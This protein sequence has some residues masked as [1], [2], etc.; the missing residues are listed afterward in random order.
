M[1]SKILLP[2]SNAAA[3]EIAQP[4][5]LFTLLSSS[6]ICA[7]FFTIDATK[8]EEK[9]Q[10]LPAVSVIESSANNSYSSSE[11]AYHKF[12]SPLIDT[13]R[14]VSTVTR[15]FMD[16][17]GATTV[18]D[19]LRNV[20]GITLAA[21]EGG[22]QGDNLMIRGFS[23][24]NDFFVDGMRDFGNY[25]RDPFNLESIE[26]LQGPSSVLF[27]RGSTGGVVQQ[28]SK[29][30]F[31]GSKKDASFTLGT[32][33]TVRATADV[34]T[35]IEG[36]DGAAF[37]LNA[38]G[39]TNK[40]AGRDAAQYRRA[41]FAPNVAFG[42]GT[43]TRLNIN[44]LHQNED[45]IPDYGVPFFAG[46]P[47][48]VKRDNFY[49]FQSNDHL[50]A[51]VDIS[52][53]KFEHDFSKDLTLRN[54]T[55]YARYTRDVSVTE[56]QITTDPAVTTRVMKIRKSL[57]TYLGNQTDLTSKFET[58]GAAHTVVTGLAVESETSSPTVFAYDNTTTNTQNPAQ[59][60]FNNAAVT[61]TSI[62]KTKI[63]TLGVY[64][65]D[66]IKL[67]KSWEISLGGRF[68]NM[69]SE[70]DQLTLATNTR[71]N[72]SHTDNLFSYSGGVVYK[73]AKN[74]SVY[75]N[76][77]TSFNPSAESLALTAPTANLAPE[78]NTMYEVGTKWDLFKK[79]LSTTM[80]IF[81]IDKD[82]AREALNAT[83]TVLSGS[84]RVDGF[85]FQ[86]SGKLTDNWNLMLGYTFMN[87]RVTKSLISDTYKNRALAN[88][89]EH[90]ASLFTTYKFK[91]EFEVG[92][93]TNFVS[94]R[95]VTPTAAPDVVSGAVR[96]VPSYLTFNLMAKYPLG[97]NITMQLNANNITNKYYH[98]QI[99][100]TQ[101]VVPGEGRVVLLTTNIKF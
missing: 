12:S 84:Q 40:V 27:G 68:D 16:D 51:N 96:N 3:S 62:T 17:R 92:G 22:N 53:I 34:N 88:T 77:G 31:L 99:R 21:G 38:V 36:I 28:N 26:V 6:V 66:T 70:L 89:P 79:R 93:G 56:P 86:A 57:E 97:K 73:P 72:L 7:S 25:F 11:S 63:D 82:N 67:G 58:F 91:S 74:G 55:R 33:E 42:L 87:S 69:Q 24:R 14:T 37:R 85:L 76:H 75:F 20:P 83:T 71:V 10:E 78:K 41:A 30:A 44:Y 80:A 61:T 2:L 8:A 32:N 100:G 35:K 94:E 46:K 45:N 23:A 50:K 29:Q 48:N 39:H 65:L 1:S 52:T 81:R 18:S 15:K 101:A 60:G 49:G 90:S 43:D 47:A 19:A 13:P 5:R 98:D 64:A 9:I 95:F 59:V 54:Q 4:S